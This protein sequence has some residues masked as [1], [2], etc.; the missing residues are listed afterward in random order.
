MNNSINELL[1]KIF[2][3]AVESYNIIEM[4]KYLSFDDNSYNEKDESNILIDFINSNDDI[5][6][7]V[8]ILLIKKLEDNV[9][10]ESILNSIVKNIEK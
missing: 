9:N 5:L 6:K 8:G 7:E 4:K 1:I 3:E 10:K 2:S